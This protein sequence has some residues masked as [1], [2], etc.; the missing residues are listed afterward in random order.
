MLDN[1]VSEVT[2]Y[3]L[4]DLGSIPVSY[5]VDISSGLH[6]NFYLMGNVGYFPGVFKRLDHEIN[7]S[8]PSKADVWNA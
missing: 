1:S 3:K 4:V 5:N 2:R 8:L 7:Q 6:T